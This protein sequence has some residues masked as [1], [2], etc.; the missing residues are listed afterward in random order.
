VVA[1]ETR[2]AIA[3]AGTTHCVLRHAISFH[4]IKNLCDCDKSR[5][6]DD[7]INYTMVKQDPIVGAVQG[8]TH[9]QIF[10]FLYQNIKDCV[11]HKSC[12]LCIVLVSHPMGDIMQAHANEMSLIC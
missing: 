2:L 10:H 1:I 12:E 8:M 6:G 5:I 4:N 11:L 9:S 7:I 3:D